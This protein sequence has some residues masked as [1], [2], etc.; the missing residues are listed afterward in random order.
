MKM[1]EVWEPLAKAW[2]HCRGTKKK[3]ARKVAKKGSIRDYQSVFPGPTPSASTENKLE[4]QRLRP[5]PNPAES[6]TL[7]LGQ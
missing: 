6:E 1:T 2:L 7:G 3:E 4:M 5:H